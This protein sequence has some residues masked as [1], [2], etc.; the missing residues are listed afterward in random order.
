MSRQAG[1]WDWD[2]SC[3]PHGGVVGWPGMQTFSVGIFQWVAK[4]SGKGVKRSKTVER[5]KGPVSRAEE[6]Y[7]K[8]RARCAELNGGSPDG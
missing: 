5:I 7:A 8:A 3:K 4:S 1:Q 6:I 2:G